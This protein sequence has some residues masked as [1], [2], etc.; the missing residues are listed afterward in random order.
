MVE[1]AWQVV[2]AIMLTWV[3]VANGVVTIRCG[4]GRQSF[5]L[6]SS[7]LTIMMA[8]INIDLLGR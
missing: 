3:V 4:G 8:A 6:L 5:G 1:I 7:L 2:I